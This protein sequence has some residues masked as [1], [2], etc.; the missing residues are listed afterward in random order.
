MKATETTV[1][2]FIGGL[3]KV[4]IIPP[5]QRNYE[6]TYEQCEELFN[7]I[8]IAYK[9]NKTHYLGNIVYYK[10]K[11]DGASYSEYILVDGQQRVTTI[12]LLLC[13]LRD[14]LPANDDSVRSINNRYLLNDTGDNRFRVRLKQTSYDTNTFMSVI[15]KTPIENNENNVLKNYNFFMKLISTSDISPVE[16][17][18]TVPKLEVVDVNLQIEN[19]LNAVQTVFEKINSTGK[20]LT[21]ADLIR[22]YLLLAQNSTEQER[23]YEDYWVKIE[24]LV[25]NDNISKFARDYLIINIFEDVPEAKIYKMFKEHFAENNA[26]HID[27]LRDMYRYSKY[28]AWMKSENCPNSKLNEIIKYLNYIKTDDIYP[29]YLYLFDKLYEDNQSELQKILRLICDFMIRYRIVSPSGGGG[30]LRS[31]VHQLLENLNSGAVQITYDEIHF[32]LS[33]SNTP[34]GRFPDDEEFSD[35]L[36]RA[37]NT[38]YAKTVLLRIEETET[39]NIPTELNKVTVEHLMPQTLSDWWLGHLNGKENAEIVFDKYLNCIG[40]LTPISQGYNSKISNNPWHDKVKELL[41]VQFSVTTELS[42]N[43]TWQEK[44]ISKRN[45]DLAKRACKAITPPLNRTRKYQTK[46]SS[47]DFSEGV[48]PVSDLTTPMS[49]AAPEFIIYEDKHHEVNT[50]KD[51]LCNICELAY[52][53]DDDLFYEIIDKN[54]IHKSTSKKNY[55]KKDPIITDKSTLL[56]DPKPI[57]G[58]IYFSEGNIS[59]DRARVYVKQL[60]DIY[61]ITDRFQISVRSR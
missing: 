34:S 33:N 12:L 23:L 17:Y 16:L 24:Q 1:L 48:Y 28:F 21:P 46:N 13:A 57:N 61:G 29:L 35:V 42:V 20:R 2:N 14:S 37:V 6:W 45:E 54:K 5:F 9:N 25:K 10:G 39:K 58:S 8:I 15:D 51:L 59:S 18:N 52:R 7:D 47:T 31:V 60:L 4:F 26:L 55:P 56:V 38:N 22:N 44:N 3:D 41:N 11:N 53:V 27:I 36:M 50:W 49:G 30:A 43:Q 32:E 40:N 19:D